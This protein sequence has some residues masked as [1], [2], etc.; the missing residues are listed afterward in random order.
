M[1]IERITLAEDARTAAGEERQVLKVM[2]PGNSD[3]C[4]IAVR[5]RSGTVTSRMAVSRAGLRDFARQ[6]AGELEWRD[7]EL[8]CGHAAT[9]RADALPGIS[10]LPCAA[11]GQPVLMIRP[12]EAAESAAEAL[13]A[14]ATPDSHREPER[15]AAALSAARDAAA[16]DRI[17]EILRD[18]EWGSAMLED[19]GEIVAGTGRPA[20]NYPDD[21]PTWGRH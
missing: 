16:L 2:I 7:W 9:G 3:R 14:P 8:A 18:P 21:R 4:A 15:A 13:R 20:E 1:T 17:Q 19:I 5:G 6:L 10:T 11:C 12:A